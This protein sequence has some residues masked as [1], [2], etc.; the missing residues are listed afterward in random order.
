MNLI[1]YVIYV[2]IYR[3]YII[4]VNSDRTQ[5]DTRNLIQV[6]LISSIEIEIIFEALQQGNLLFI[7]QADY[8]QL[9]F[10]LLITSLV[11]PFYSSILIF[12]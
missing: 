5:I 2:S 3:I 4:K 9:K 12:P 11:T 10:L 8:A 6:N 7:L 1:F